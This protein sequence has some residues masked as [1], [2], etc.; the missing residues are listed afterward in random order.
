M[1]V[2][3]MPKKYDVGEEC[4][5]LLVEDLHD[6]SSLNPLVELVDDHEQMHEAPRCLLERPHHVEVPHS[7][8]PCDGYGLKRLRQE[9]SLLSIELAALA[10]PHDIFGVCYRCGPVKPL[11]ESFPDKSSWTGVM[12]A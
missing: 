10:A 1:N 7:K 2:F 12:S 5:G 4:Y 3:G 11:S 9:V 6:G 8:W